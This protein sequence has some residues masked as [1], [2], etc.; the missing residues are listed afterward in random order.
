MS[1]EPYRVGATIWVPKFAQS[2][3]G[4]V[5]HG[6][7]PLTAADPDY[8]TWDRYMKLKNRRVVGRGPGGRRVG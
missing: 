6:Y 2:T 4:D 1:V 7:V 3:T 8:A 5:G